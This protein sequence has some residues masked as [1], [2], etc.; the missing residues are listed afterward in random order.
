MANRISRVNELIKREVSKILIR[1]VEFPKDILTTVTRVE[2]SSN[3]IQ[4]K[5]YISV[6]PENQI[7]KVLKILNQQIF[8]IQQILNKRLKMRPIPKIKFVEEKEVKE[9]AKIEQLLGEIKRKK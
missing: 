9:A 4:S 3:F 8:G 6:I 2:T 7:I 1:E 5:V